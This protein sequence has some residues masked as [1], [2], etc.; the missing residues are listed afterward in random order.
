MTLQRGLKR[1]GIPKK[2][3]R[4]KMIPLKPYRPKKIIRKKGIRNWELGNQEL[5][6]DER[7]KYE[8]GGAPGNTK[9]SQQ[10]F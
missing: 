9:P 6:K 3:M 7:S 2:A 5:K 10:K 8:T 4:I 1:I